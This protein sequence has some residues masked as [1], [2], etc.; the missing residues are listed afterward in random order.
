MLVSIGDCDINHLIGHKFMM[1]MFPSISG[2]DS[3]SMAHFRPELVQRI[4]CFTQIEHFVLVER[5]C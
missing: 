1:Q 4:I 5:V 2:F 3:G